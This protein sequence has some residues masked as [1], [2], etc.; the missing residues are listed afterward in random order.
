MIDVD[1]KFILEVASGIID[2]AELAEKYG[3]SKEE[4]LFLK[5]Y[6]P[7]VKQVESKKTELKANGYTFRMKSA[8]LAEDLLEDVYLKA[9][10]ADASF[11]TQLEALKFMAR[12]AGLD[13][14]V[15]EQ[16]QQGPGFSITINLGNGQSV[17][18]GQ[19]QQAKDVTDVEEIDKPDFSFS[20]PEYTPVPFSEGAA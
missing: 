16:V 6:E 5:E 20:L 14:P 7:F 12:A 1:P 9:K 10:A 11:H 2:P 8:V 4:W 18:I 17:Q 3:Y 19:T 15:R 13:A